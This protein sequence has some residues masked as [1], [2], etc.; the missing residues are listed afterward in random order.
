MTQWGKPEITIPAGIRSPASRKA[1]QQLLDQPRAEAWTFDLAEFELTHIVLVNSSM[2]RITRRQSKAGSKLASKP[3]S[4][5]PAA[6]R[7]GGHSR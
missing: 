7:R 6:T 4:A 2:V 5:V 3:A 1:L